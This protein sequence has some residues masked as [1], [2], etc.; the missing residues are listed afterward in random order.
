MSDAGNVSDDD[1]KA[2]VKTL[3]EEHVTD[4]ENLTV[5]EAAEAFFGHDLNSPQIDR[6][7]RLMDSAQVE[8]VVKW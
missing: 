7:F 4:V 2:Y 6:V 3:F 5:H 8:V 1:L